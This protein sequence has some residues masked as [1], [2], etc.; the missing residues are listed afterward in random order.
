M[1][2]LFKKKKKS[3]PRSESPFFKV[4]DICLNNKLHKPKHSWNSHEL[5][6]KREKPSGGQTSKSSSAGSSALCSGSCS[7]LKDLKI[8]CGLSSWLHIFKH[9]QCCLSVSVRGPR[10]PSTPRCISFHLTGSFSAS[11]AI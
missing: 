11:V 1:A 9:V 5:I 6:C 8:C 4:C 7:A 2:F 3:F 10:Q